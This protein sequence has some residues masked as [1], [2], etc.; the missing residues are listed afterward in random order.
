V[1]LNIPLVIIG[2]RGYAVLSLFLVANLLTTCGLVPIILALVTPL[3][4]FI[5]ETGEDQRLVHYCRLP[6]QTLCG[7]GSLNR[8]LGSLLTSSAVT[9]LLCLQTGERGCWEMWMRLWDVGWAL[10][11]SCLLSDA[12]RRGG[13][14]HRVANLGSCTGRLY[15]TCGSSC[16]TINV[17]HD[18]MSQ[19]SAARFHKGEGCCS[20][21]GR[22]TTTLLSLPASCV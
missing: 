3:R 5:T 16:R 20:Q 13:Q 18:L 1:L 11:R 10:N 15:T 2:T 8:R 22:C 14:G 21:R 7:L 4:G 12:F 19:A 9:T 17:G 6:L